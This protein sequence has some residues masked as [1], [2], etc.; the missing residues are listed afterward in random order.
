MTRT[1][2]RTGAG[3]DEVAPHCVVWSCWQLRVL[4]TTLSK[5][6]WPG[7]LGAEGVTPCNPG[8]EQAGKGKPR[9]ERETVRALKPT[10]AVAVGGGKS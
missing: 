7:G 2:W 8:P 1:V 3:R 5:L 6:L 10:E 4:K 9:A